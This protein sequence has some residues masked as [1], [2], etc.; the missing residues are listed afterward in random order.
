MSHD[1]IDFVEDICLSLANSFTELWNANT[2][3]HYKQPMHN[4]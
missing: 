1:V 2:I 4:K 3:T